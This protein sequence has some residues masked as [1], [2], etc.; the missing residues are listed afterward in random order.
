MKAILKRLFAFI[1]S[2]SKM[3]PTKATEA[4]DDRACHSNQQLTNVEIE[5]LTLIE[6]K[7]ANDPSVL[8]WW[9]A[10]NKVDGPKIIKKLC[11]NNYLALAGYE[12]NVRKATIPIL[13][14]FLKKHGLSVKGKKDELVI[15]IIDNI[16]EADCLSYFTQSYWVSTP[17]A[18]ELLRAEKIKAQVEYDRKEKIISE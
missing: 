13:K 8:G 9:C 14:D 15:R 6:G 3:R 18:V 11:K 5:F 2:P 7:K 12:F 10:F 17:K 1:G 16:C 4:L